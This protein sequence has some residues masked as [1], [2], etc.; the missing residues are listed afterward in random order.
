MRITNRWQNFPYVRE[1][2][3]KRQ[4]G[5]YALLARI[6]AHRATCEYWL[7]IVITGQMFYTFRDTTDGKA[8]KI[9]VQSTDDD[10]DDLMMMMIINVKI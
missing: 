10:D 4:I 7:H 9:S 2:I 8:N 6:T 3:S 1:T 5:P